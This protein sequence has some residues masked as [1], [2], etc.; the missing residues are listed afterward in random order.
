M[1]EITK[2]QEI[3][4]VQIWMDIPKQE[5]NRQSMWFTDRPIDFRRQVRNWYLDSVTIKVTSTTWSS[6]QFIILSLDL[7][8][9][10]RLLWETFLH[11]S[12][13][14]AI[15]IPWP[16]TYLITSKVSKWSW[17]AATECILKITQNASSTI[18][19]VPSSTNTLNSDQYWSWSFVINASKWD[20]IWFTW[21]T[22]NANWIIYMETRIT[23]IS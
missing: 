1:E 4:K 2:K 22:D 14:W 13:Y 3:Q 20:Y 19:R 8:K 12:T 5:F 7:T 11:L 17:S 18:W 21:N 10:G 15:Y 16:W 23:K 6:N 9:T